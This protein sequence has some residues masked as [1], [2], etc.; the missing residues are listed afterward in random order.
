M[1][2]G[3]ERLTLAEIADRPRR[4]RRPRARGEAPARR[5]RGR[6][7]HDLES[8]HVRRRA[9]HRRAQP[10]AGGDPRRRRDRRTAQSRSDGELA[11]RPMLTLT[12]TFD[13]R[14]V[15]GAPAA[16]FLQTRQGAAGGARP[17]A[18]ATDLV[19]GPRARLARALLHATCS[20]S[21]RRSSTTTAPGR[22]L[23][24]GATEIALTIGEPTEEGGVAH[25]DVDDVKA[26]AS[27]CRQPGSRSASSVELHGAIR[28]STSST[29]TATGSSSP[30]RSN[31]PP[32]RRRRT[33]VP[34]RH[35]PARVLLA[36]DERARV[37][38]AA[39]T[40]LRRAL[41]PAGRHGRWSPSDGFAARRGRLVPALPAR[42]SPASASSTR[43]RRS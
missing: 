1:I 14:A 32:R 5:P 8:R 37:G 29:P 18:V 4:P 33:P 41:G 25:V 36:R 6:H 30:R 39:R 2:R 23:D 38:R 17:D 21:T 12:R 7:V 22:A 15:D 9:V 13:H 35:A 27:G 11:V 3:A 26:E 28:C 31:D 40:A 24:R 20:A 42:T 34:A 19:P 16:G 43:R 10:A